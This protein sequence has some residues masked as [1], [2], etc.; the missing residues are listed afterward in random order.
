MTTPTLLH[1]IYLGLGSNLGDKENNLKEALRHI[2][3][4]I[5]KV[6]A[7]SPIYET[8]PDGFE[9]DNHFLNA[10]CHVRTPLEALEVLEVTQI[11]ERELGRCTKSVNHRY[12][13]RTIDI[14]LLLF[15]NQEFHYPHLI[16]PHPQLH[17][18]G[19]VLLPLADI[20]PQAEHPVLHKT[21]ARLRDEYISQTH[22]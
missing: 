15:D 1:D 17:L 10:A 21:I 5:G 16:I 20:A 11:I 12:S 13:D 19:F 9:S 3:Q 6:E 14:D 8:A 2:A 4:R 22:K 18:R 7:L